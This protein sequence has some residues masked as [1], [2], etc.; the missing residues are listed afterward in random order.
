VI[1]ILRD[2][3]IMDHMVNK[4]NKMTVRELREI[5]FDMDQDLEVT[6]WKPEWDQT[7]PINRVELCE[8]EVVIF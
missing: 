7:D 6:V 8:S 5:L 3:A 1:D 4:G 2:E